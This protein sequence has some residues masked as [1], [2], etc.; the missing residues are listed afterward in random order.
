MFLFLLGG[1]SIL[2]S[3]NAYDEWDLERI[4]WGEP[5]KSWPQR[6]RKRSAECDFSLPGLAR[7]KIPG[8]RRNQR[9]H[10]RSAIL[11]SR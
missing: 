8:V 4:K 3:L 6:W 1:G 2:R 10:R 9:Y 11:P 7:R 5:P